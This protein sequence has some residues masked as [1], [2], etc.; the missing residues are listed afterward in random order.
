[1]RKNRSVK[2]DA[3]DILMTLIRQKVNRPVQNLSYKQVQSMKND[4]KNGRG[5]RTPAGNQTSG[6]GKDLQHLKSITKL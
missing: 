4:L 6:T 3:K 2:N 5:F 1:M